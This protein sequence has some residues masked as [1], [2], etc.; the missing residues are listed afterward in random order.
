ML[1]IYPEF[2][3]LEITDKEAIENITGNF[4]PYSDFN[5]VSLYSYNTDNDALISNLHGNLVIKFRDYI[6]NGPFYSF[7]GNT[8]AVETAGELL[9]RAKNENAMHKLQL[10]PE[11]VILADARLME[12]YDVIEDKDNFDYV[13]DVPEVATLEGEKYHNKR[14]A[15]NR[16]HANSPDHIVKTLDLTNLEIQK[17]VIDLFDLWVKVRNKNI[18]ETEHEKKAVLRLIEAS[19]KLNLIAIGVYKENKLIGFAIA[20]LLKNDYAIFHF[21]KANTEHKGIFESLYMFKAKELLKN[22]VKFW[23]IEQDLGIENLRISKQ[24]WNPAHFLKKYVITEKI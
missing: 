4:P 10:I 17:E 5:F 14:N 2:K 3:N 18:Q 16:F 22:Q 6:T 24:Q 20:E 1:P 19:N 21:I 15:V 13:L 9:M 23:N 7:L 12:A 11:S 8:K